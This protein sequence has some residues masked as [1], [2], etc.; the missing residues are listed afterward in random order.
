[1]ATDFNSVTLIGR[2]TADPVSKYLP[3]GSAVAEFSIANNY[4][5]S[6][7]NATE[8]NYFD[9]VAFGK[10]AET[11]SKYLTKGKQV[12][13]MG[14]LRQERWQDKDTNTARSKVRIIMQS[15]QMLGTSAN[16]ASGMD[17]AYSLSASSGNVDLGS[18]EDD[19]EVPF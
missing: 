19:D 3:S 10:M 6:S 1:M 2:L 18:F 11:V 7:K 16:A 9:V 14:T 13:V 4:Y 12:A 8:V 17:T 15:M 5:V